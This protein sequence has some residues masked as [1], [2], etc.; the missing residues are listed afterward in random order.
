MEYTLRRDINVQLCPIVVY[1]L[2]GFESYGVPMWRKL[3]SEMCFSL[4]VECVGRDVHR[5]CFVWK[6]H[7]V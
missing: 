2:Q 3:S 4:Q 1:L 7:C 5:S 6:V